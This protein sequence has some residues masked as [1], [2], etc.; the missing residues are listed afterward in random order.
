MSCILVGLSTLKL[1]PN[2][3]TVADVVWTV[4][5]D[6]LL[7]A[8]H[9]ALV[10]LATRQQDRSCTTQ[11]NVFSWLI[12]D[13]AVSVLRLLKNPLQFQANRVINRNGSHWANP[14]DISNTWIAYFSPSYLLCLMRLYTLVDWLTYLSWILGA[15]AVHL[16]E[17]CRNNLIVN[18]GYYEISISTLFYVISIIT[19]ILVFGVHRISN[20]RC[21]P[22]FSIR[23]TSWP[24]SC[25]SIHFDRS[26]WRQPNES[27]EEYRV[28][29]VESFNREDT[30]VVQPA[31]LHQMSIEDMRLTQNEL[32]QLKTLRY[33]PSIPALNTVPSTQ[34]LH[35][36]SSTDQITRQPEPM[37]SQET[38][39]GD[40]GRRG[41]QIEMLPILSTPTI[42]T[43]DP[44]IPTPILSVPSQENMKTTDNTCA[45]CLEDYEPNELL[46]ELNCGHRY[47][48]SCVDDWL[49]KT[50]RVCPVCNA[51]AVGKP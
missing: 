51:D 33:T 31:P 8:W 2:E 28:R 34:T 45:L 39:G 44:K 41:S 5:R 19:Y 18:A 15:W 22:G 21:F 30:V 12:F 9:S 11:S 40:G 27:L 37:P 43:I 36:D 47:H 50:K 7:I 10:I 13:I 26:Q 14:Q 42:L 32:H 16:I 29:V 24:D 20:G 1:D 49:T 48:A 35:G 23:N 3:L 17:G 25:P 6:F 46:R 4:S 38:L